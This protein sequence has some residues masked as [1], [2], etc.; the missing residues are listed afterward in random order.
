VAVIQH[1]WNSI[2]RHPNLKI[3]LSGSDVAFMERQVLDED[4]QL[5]N[6]RTAARRREQPEYAG[7]ALFF[8]DYSVS[9]RPPCQRI[10][11]PSRPRMARH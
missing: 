11:S 4:A 8:P 9:G 5:Y 10:R 1:W 2:K 6:R 7:S 3:L